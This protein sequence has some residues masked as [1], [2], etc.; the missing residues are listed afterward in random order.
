M[1]LPETDQLMLDLSKSIFL[2]IQ[3]M[4]TGRRLVDLSLASYYFRFL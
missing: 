4:Q 3:A 2:E 1:K